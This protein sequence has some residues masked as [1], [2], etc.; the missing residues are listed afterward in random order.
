MTVMPALTAALMIIGNE[1]LS[2][3]TKDAN[4]PWIA[5]KLGARGIRLREVRVV[6]DDRE[7]IVAAVNHLRARYTYVFTTGGIG[8]THD[9]ITSE[10]MAAAFGVPH[11]VDAEA[12]GRLEAYYQ[13]RGIEMNAARLRMATLPQGALLIDNPVSVAP[14]FNIGNVFVMAGIPGVMQ[15]MWTHVETMIGEGAPALSAAVNC[16]LKEGDLAADLAAIQARYPDIDIGSYPASGDKGY[17]VS[18]V[19]SGYD[20]IRLQAA[21][22]EVRD[23][24]LRLGGTP[25]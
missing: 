10:C 12:R 23:M 13:S 16:S 18:L 11:V 5:E 2:G 17:T 24:V 7:D 3:K 22:Q 15:A 14:G 1:I 21:A 6:A 4:T 20:A 8:P 19:L 9:D 25:S